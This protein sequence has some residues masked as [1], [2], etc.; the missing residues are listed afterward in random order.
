MP[1]TK[2]APKK[3]RVVISNAEAISRLRRMQPILET[4]LRW[5][6]R[7]EATLEVGNDMVGEMTNRS[8]PGAA[9]YNTIRR[10]L[11]YDLAMHLARLFD[12]GAVRVKP[13]KRDVASIPL[14]IRLIR[15]KRCRAA[16]VK[17]AGETH[18]HL[19]LGKRFESECNEAIDRASKAY[20]EIFRGKFGA[21]GV[22]AL[23]QVRDN[24]IAHSL[25]KEVEYDVI[26]HQLF[27]LV[28]DASG[29]IEAASIAIIGSA[30]Q[31]EERQMQYRKEAQEFWTQAFAQKVAAA[32]THDYEKG[33]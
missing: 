27:R 19:G 32:E 6:L 20:S 5:A 33:A 28:K 11:S 14:M 9:A 26:Y 2:V 22:K 12:R 13:N 16:L 7:I 17:I 18:P 29:I 25:M 10:S 1:K 30:P 8:I 15:Q 23:K 4:N 31:M 3:K 21:S 24:H